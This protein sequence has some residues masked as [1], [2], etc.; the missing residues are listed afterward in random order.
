MRV[1]RAAALVLVGWYL[2]IPPLGAH[3]PNVAASVNQ[4]MYAPVKRKQRYAFQPYSTLEEC[5]ARK[6]KDL[7]DC[8]VVEGEDAHFTRWAMR[9]KRRGAETARA[10]ANNAATEERIRTLV[11]MTRAGAFQSEESCD[12]KRAALSKLDPALGDHRQ[13]PAE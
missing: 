11:A 4:W 5:E 10:A 8:I 12:A 6:G 9:E 13:L 1:W 2:M 3:R 7:N